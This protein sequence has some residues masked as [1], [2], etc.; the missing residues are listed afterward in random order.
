LAALLAAPFALY[1]LPGA[2]RA[3]VLVTVPAGDVHPGTALSVNGFGSPFAFH[4]GPRFTPATA[5]EL[6][7]AQA[8]QL[9]AAVLA[10]PAGT[11]L[12]SASSGDPGNE[13]VKH[14]GMAAGDPGGGT[15]GDPGGGTPLLLVPEPGGLALALVGAGLAGLAALRRGNRVR[16]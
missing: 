9:L 7:P 16:E 5:V 15:N 4:L 13:A 8:A 14:P 1:N 11:T 3:E 12:V 10:V 6:A 2:A